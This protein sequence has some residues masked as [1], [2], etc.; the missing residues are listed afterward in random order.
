MIGLPEILVVSVFLL[1]WATVVW[2]A[3]RIAR[4]LGFTPWLGLLAVIPMVNLILLWFVAL[5]E[6]PAMVPKDSV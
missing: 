6:W 2:P 4:R 5:A 3:A 1:I